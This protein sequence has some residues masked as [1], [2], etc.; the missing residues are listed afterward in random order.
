[1]TIKT[2]QDIISDLINEI[3]ESLQSAQ[4]NLSCISAIGSG[5]KI[6]AEE[7]DKLERL[8]DKL[9]GQIEASLKLSA[10]LHKSLLQCAQDNDIILRAGPGDKDDQ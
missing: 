6:S 2:P 8:K 3:E 9:Q 4:D 10:L 7:R 1:M 5:V